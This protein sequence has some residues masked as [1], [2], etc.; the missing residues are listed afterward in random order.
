MTI[1]PSINGAKDFLDVEYKLK[2]IEG[3]AD[4]RLQRGP[5]E[6]GGWVHLDIVDGEFAEPKSWPYV[7]DNPEDAIEELKDVK[8]KC[9][10]GLHLMVSDPQEN[11]DE[12]MDT[13]VER[14][15][16]QYESPEHIQ[17]AL[18][19][20][21]MTKIE[22]GVV[23]ALDTPVE[24]IGELPEK[25][26]FVQLMSI[27]KIGHYGEHFQSEILKKIDAAKKM[28]PNIKISVDG[29]IKEEHLKDLAKAGAD[30][31]V[32][33]SAIFDAADPAAEL[34]RLQ[35]LV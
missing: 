29:G 3:V 19:V 28:Y 35:A 22:S 16:I 6:G 9:K 4:H 17:N 7:G 23:L 26:K 2:Q 14:I 24:V 13:P 27:G 12:W 31:V 30:Q 11:L 32:M 8:T 5:A 25:I 15:L 21:D 1:A 33:G 18:A 20:L 10:L 34:K